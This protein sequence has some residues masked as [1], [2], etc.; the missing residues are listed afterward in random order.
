MYLNDEV[1]IDE[2]LELFQNDWIKEST[3][4]LDEGKYN[5]YHGVGNNS[6][7][8]LLIQEEIIVDL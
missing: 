8:K 1:L 7:I 5:V 6:L 3:L 2:E 4:T